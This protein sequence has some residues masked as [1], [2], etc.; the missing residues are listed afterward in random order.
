MQGKGGRV[1]QVDGVNGIDC[2]KLFVVRGGLN[3]RLVGKGNNGKRRWDG[4]VK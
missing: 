4:N 2:V 3:V 1:D